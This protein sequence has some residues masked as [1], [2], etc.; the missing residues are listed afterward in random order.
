M[1]KRRSELNRLYDA[2]VRDYGILNARANKS[3]FADD[4]S[5]SLL[6]SLEVLDDEGKFVRKADMFSKRTIKQRVVVTAVDTA[7]EALALSLAE[8]TKVDMDYMVQLTGKTEA[9]IVHDLEGVIFLN[10]LYGKN[11]P[12]QKRAQ[13]SAL[14]ITVPTWRRWSVCSPPI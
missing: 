6:S 10:P 8:K 1:T 9:E 12:G 4:N 7:S 2:F 3:V 11:L 5:A 14:R 13:N